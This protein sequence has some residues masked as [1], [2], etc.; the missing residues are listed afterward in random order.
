MADMTEKVRVEM[1]KLVLKLMKCRDFKEIKNPPLL[2]QLIINQ[3]QDPIT[4][5]QTTQWLLEFVAGK[6][7]MI[8]PKGEKKPTKIEVGWAEE[9]ALIDES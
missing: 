2:T 4:K 1:Q 9:Q 8:P 6:T 7:G 3:L 5:R